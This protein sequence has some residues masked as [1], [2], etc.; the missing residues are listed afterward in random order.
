MIIIYYILHIFL[1]KLKTGFIPDKYISSICVAN[2]T[3]IKK[4]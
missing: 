4:N 1:L 2:N 3:F